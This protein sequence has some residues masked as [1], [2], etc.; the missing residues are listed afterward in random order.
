MARI[1]LLSYGCEPNRGSEAGIGWHWAQHLSKTHDVILLTHP[2]GRRAI[3]AELAKDPRPRLRIRYVELPAMLDPWRLVPGEQLIQPRYI[4]WQFAAYKVARRIMEYEEIDLVHHVSWT[5]MTGPTLGWKL[6]KPFIWGPIGSG[7]QAPLQMR[8]F[9]GTK[10]W[11]REAF[12]NL[13]VKSVGFNPLAR[14][15]ARH[16]AFTFASNPDT[17]RALKQLGADPIV[18]QPDA[19]VDFDWLAPAPPV[20]RDRDR[21]VIAWASRLM[22]R[23]APGLAIEAFAKLRQERSAELWFLGDGPLI[24]DCRELAAKLGVEQDVR[25]LGWVPHRQVKT[26]LSEADIFL[27]T[28]LRDTCPMPVMEAMACALPVIALD[29]HGIKNFPDEAVLKV[30]VGRPEDLVD[31]VAAALRLLANDPELR[32]RRAAAAWECARSAHLWE[33]RYAGVERAYEMILGEPQVLT[34][35]W[36]EVCGRAAD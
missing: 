2:R 6:G 16:S 17:L 21:L 8:R 28:S 7:Q 25:F 30:P 15:A 4:M 33:H 11:L 31:D 9:L 22:T 13:Q 3:Q 23:K 20:P 1:L 27:F 32:A 36:E 34:G 14:A 24:S 35:D 26:V 12:R 5:T 29:L 18:L 10:G 19:A